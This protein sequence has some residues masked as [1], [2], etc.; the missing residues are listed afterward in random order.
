M[1]FHITLSFLQWK[2]VD[3][4]EEIQ[5]EQD[6]TPEREIEEN[7]ERYIQDLGNTRVDVKYM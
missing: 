7:M 1:Y 2:I 3:Q 5:I 4:E 6:Y